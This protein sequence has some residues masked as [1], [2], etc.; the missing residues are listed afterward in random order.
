MSGSTLRD[1][2]NQ[3][4]YLGSL[5]NPYDRDCT[6]L[7][8]QYIT[9]L[10]FE[11]FFAAILVHVSEAETHYYHSLSICPRH[12]EQPEEVLYVFEDF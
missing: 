1:H 5:K 6:V 11:L 4:T 12:T 7:L 10:L 8:S 9:I 3:H 2:Q